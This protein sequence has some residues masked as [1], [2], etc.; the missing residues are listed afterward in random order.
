MLQEATAVLYNFIK[1]GSGRT[2]LRRLFEIKS[3]GSFVSMF[4]LF[5]V[6]TQGFPGLSRG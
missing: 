6:T 1:T 5:F 4:Q 2:L 3:Q